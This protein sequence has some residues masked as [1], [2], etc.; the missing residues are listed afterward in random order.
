MKLIE[1]KSLGHIRM[2][3][4]QLMSS[5]H[6]RKNPWKSIMISGI[7]TFKQIILLFMSCLRSEKIHKLLTKSYD[8]F[9]AHLCEIYS[10]GAIRRKQQITFLLVNLSK[11]CQNVVTSTSTK[12]QT[13]SPDLAPGSVCGQKRHASCPA[14]SKNT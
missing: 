14:R 10:T 9:Q 5:S 12:N 11:Y 13:H 4:Q 8:H 1:M 3:F 7:Q 6:Y 2:I